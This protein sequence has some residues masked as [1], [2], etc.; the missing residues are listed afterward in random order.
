MKIIV[1]PA[2]EMSLENPISKDWKIK[3]N[4][5]EIVKALASLDENELKKKL[6]INDNILADVNNYIDGFNNNTTYK[7]LEMYNGLA[8]RSLDY[9]S[10]DDIAKDYLD[11]NLYI[12]SAFY[13]PNKGDSL[14]KP[15]R[16]DMTH[17]I[18][19]DGKSLKN[20][21]KDVFTES[22][23]NEDIVI[24]LASNEFSDLIDRNKVKI[25]DFDFYMLKNGELKSHSTTS[26]KG[27]GMVARFM[28]IN[29]I[30]NIDDIKNFNLDG[31][32][33][34]EEKSSDNKFVFIKE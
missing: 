14:V 16:L 25:L 33:F 27:R 13:G 4:T 1:S 20:L 8:F 6:K 21:W 29:Q 30:K 34:S 31:Y 18:K 2:K 15:Y 9:K 24:N 12:L 17:S 26:K 19:I 3:E 22:L 32:K 10:L 5:Q 28:A 23:E 7:A 11:N